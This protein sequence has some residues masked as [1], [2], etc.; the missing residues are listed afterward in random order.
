SS[1]TSRT[2][3]AISAWAPGSASSPWLRPSPWR[4]DSPS[5]R[6]RGRR[7]L[8]VAKIVRRE[9]VEHVGA[10]RELAAQ[11]PQDRA[12]PVSGRSEHAEDCP[13]GEPQDAASYRAG[14]GG[15][16]AKWSHPSIRCDRRARSGRRV[17]RSW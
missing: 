10:L 5:P 2:A 6:G 1:C 7:Y 12:R 4:A 3:T 14:A 15:E 17:F 11:G 9:L 16:M 8:V 13:E